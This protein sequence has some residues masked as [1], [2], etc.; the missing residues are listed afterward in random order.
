MAL[1]EPEVAPSW[2]DLPLTLKVTPLGA[3]DF[4]SRL[5]TRSEQVA[6]AYRRKKKVLTSCCVVEVAIQELLNCQEGV[7]F[8]AQ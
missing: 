5:P 8:S 4:T 1:T 6:T 2:L 7:A 3:V